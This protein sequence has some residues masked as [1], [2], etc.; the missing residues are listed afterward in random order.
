MQMW[1]TCSTCQEK[2]FGGWPEDS[3][4]EDIPGYVPVQK[5]TDCQLAGASNENIG[6]TKQKSDKPKKAKEN[7]SSVQKKWLEEAKKLGSSRII[8]NSGEVSETRLRPSVSTKRWSLYA[9]LTEQLFNAQIP[10][11]RH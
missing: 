1:D 11:R 8:T 10:T 4:L 9:Q 6:V 5:I 7:L 2:D 3:E